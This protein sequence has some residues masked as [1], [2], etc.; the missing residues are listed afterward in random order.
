MTKSIFDYRDYKAYLRDLAKSKGLR[1]GFKARM[2]D[3]MNCQA[4]YI[5]QVLTGA[6]H[7][8]LE[9]AEALARFLKLEEQER[10]YFFLAV[11]FA[12]AGTVQLRRHFQSEMD[13]HLERRLNL[14]ERFGRQSELTKEAQSIYYGCWVY[15]AVHI[16][17]TIPELRTVEALA[18]HFRLPRKTVAEALS[19]LESLQLAQRSGSNYRIGTTFLRVGNDS[20]NL[21]RHH[22]NW[23]HQAT[24]SLDRQSKRDAHYSAV[25]SL[26][27]A[28]AARVKE[29]IFEMIAD[30]TTIVKDSKEEVIYGICF[31]LF[32]L[33]R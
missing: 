11:Q 21:N 12:R 29:R 5:S 19:F 26:S 9:Q 20:P 8:S 33:R 23:R 1:S 13:A 10:S 3:A 2:A 16:A 25:V 15:A 24:E 14:V 6:Q 32:D 7:L 27:E 28:D 30:V 18:D 17:L 22:M 4:T 31:D